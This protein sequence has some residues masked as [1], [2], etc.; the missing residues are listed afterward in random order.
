MMGSFFR[1][2]HTTHLPPGEADARMCWTCLFQAK[3]L[4]LSGGCVLAPGVSGLPGL[5]M[6]QMKISESLAPEASKFVW[7]GLKSNAWTA[8]GKKNQSTSSS[9]RTLLLIPNILIMITTIIFTSK[10]HNHYHDYHYEYQVVCSNIH[11][12]VIWKMVWTRSG[13]S[14]VVVTFRVRVVF[15]KTVESDWHFDKLC[16]TVVTFKA[17]DHCLTTVFLNLLYSHPGHNNRNGFVLSVIIYLSSPSR[18][19]LPVCLSVWANT[20]SSFSPL[21]ILFAL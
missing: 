6:S 14:L 16:G 5:V 3:Q 9:Y 4:M 15:R 8:P 7:K 2:S 20:R 12:K 17:I 10:H 13:N 21:S 11:V 1:K 19:F 18:K